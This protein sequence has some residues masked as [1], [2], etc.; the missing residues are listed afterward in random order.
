MKS[1]IIFLMLGFFFPNITFC[2][3]LGLEVNKVVSIQTNRITKIID[4]EGTCT[5]LNGHLVNT[6]KSAVHLWTLNVNA[7]S[8]SKI[9]LTIDY[10]YHLQRVQKKYQKEKH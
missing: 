3:D 4:L 6:C 5:S 9:P 1:L 2:K 8:K 10:I 7:K